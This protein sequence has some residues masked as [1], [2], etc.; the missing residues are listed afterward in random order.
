[1]VQTCMDASVNK[2]H[3]DEEEDE[4]EDGYASA[5]HSAAPPLHTPYQGQRIIRI[6]TWRAETDTRVGP[7]PPFSLAS[8]QSLLS[9]ATATSDDALALCIWT[10]WGEQVGQTQATAA[11]SAAAHARPLEFMP[12]TLSCRSLFV[13]AL[14]LP[15][16]PRAARLRISHP[17]EQCHA[18]LDVLA[19]HEN[20]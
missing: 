18:F 6:R 13:T 5:A 3:A 19:V 7:A 4:E 17:S 8:V 16:P 1:M 11:S 2:R 20:I 15:A 10:E 12:G 9:L 14:V